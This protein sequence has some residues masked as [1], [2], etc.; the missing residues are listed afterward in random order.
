MNVSKN[1]AVWAR[2][3]LAG[4]AS[5][6]DCTIMSSGVRGSQS[7]G[8]RRRTARTRSPISTSGPHRVVALMVYPPAWKRVY[9]D[10]TT[11]RHFARPTRDRAILHAVFLFFGGLMFCGPMPAGDDLQVSSGFLR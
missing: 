8:V 3:H 10:L 4:E 5:E 9:P 11:F 2:C 1:H 7:A 6:M